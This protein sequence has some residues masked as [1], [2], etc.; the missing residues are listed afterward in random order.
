[1]G[2][3]AWGDLAY[4]V[5]TT[6]LAVLVLVVFASGLVG[7]E[8]LDAT[9]AAEVLST[10]PILAGI[11]VGLALLV[12]VRS[13]VRSGPLALEATDVHHLLLAPIDRSRVLRTPA[14]SMVAYSAAAAA[15][16]GALAGELLSQRLSGTGAAWLA[17]GALFG[18]TTALLA[19]GAA[20]LTASRRVPRPGPELLAVALLAWS[21]ADLFDV[22][23]TAP[24]TWVGRMVFWPVQF[25]AAALGGVAVAGALAVAGIALVGG[26]SIE[27]ARRRTVLVGQ[28]RFA[29]TQQDLRS[30][31]LLRRQLAAEVP[32]HRSLVRHL[33]V[34]LGRRFPVFTR[35]L[36]SLLR[37]PTVR[38]VRVLVLVIGAAFA[39]R[40]TFAGT[41]PMLLVAGV[42]TFVAALDA[43]EP[44]AQEVDHPTMLG[45]YPRP[46]GAVL[47]QHLAA[48]VLLMLLAGG[49]AL[50]VTEA[51]SPSNEVLQVG[52][53]TLVSGAVAAVAGAAVSVVS[54]IKLD[55]GQAAMF[56]PEVAGPTVVIRTL[57]PPTVATIGLVPVLLAQRASRIDSPPVGPAVT[58]AVVSLVLSGLVFLWVRYRA[59]MHEA[60]G[61]SAKGAGT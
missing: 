4:R 11:V 15:A 31:L 33:P 20:M 21:V 40:A 43:I 48:P 39:L 34:G 12:G 1:M 45:S 59:E 10:G 56:N 30:V 7:D 54:E 27:G 16:V 35:D 5:Y 36:Q 47:V 6:A 13:G 22:A 61:L 32:R 2:D 58:A 57:W 52:A 46:A 37:W 26:L 8:R 9:Q 28:L 38:I 14:I 53:I 24:L 23:P 60:A 25:Q 41:T 49:V 29:V 51:V 42:L 44:L 17:S 55:Q 50:G 18:A 3:V 19:L